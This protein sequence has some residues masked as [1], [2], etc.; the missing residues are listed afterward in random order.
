MGRN[1]IRR[2]R[3]LTAAARSAQTAAR[4]GAV[5]V[6]HGHLCRGA[7]GDDGYPVIQC[8]YFTLPGQGRVHYE[9]SERA[10]RGGPRGGEDER[11]CPPSGKGSRGVPVLTG[12]EIP[13]P[14]GGLSPSPRGNGRPVLSFFRTITAPKSSGLVPVSERDRLGDR[15]LGL[16]RAV[17]SSSAVSGQLRCHVDRESGC[18]IYGGSRAAWSNSRRRFARATALAKFDQAKAREPP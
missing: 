2:R 15:R 4:R 17:Q 9:R 5:M 12:Y 10:A 3:A 18:P 6:G 7:N 13:L 14:A 16:C 11:T 8:H 1:L